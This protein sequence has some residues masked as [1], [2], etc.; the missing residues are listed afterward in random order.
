MNATNTGV[1]ISVCFQFAC[2]IQV[3]HRAPEPTIAQMRDPKSFYC[4]RKKNSNVFPTPAKK[5]RQRINE[6]IPVYRGE[7]VPLP[8]HA[9]FHAWEAGIYMYATDAIIP[10]TLMRA[11]QF[12]LA[13]SNISTRV[14][15]ARY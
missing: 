15:R 1:I 10:L 11:I 13:V 8:H 14:S 5:L 3:D 4:T 9:L 6:L 12:H 2:E 7:G